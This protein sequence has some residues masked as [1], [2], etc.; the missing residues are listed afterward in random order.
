MLK[1]IFA[2]TENIEG[3]SGYVMDIIDQLLWWLLRKREDSDKVK[4]SSRFS[5]VSNLRLLI[6]KCNLRDFLGGPVAKTLHSQCR[7]PGFH[8]WTRS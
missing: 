4:K 5:H 3:V 2:P 6:T 1:K 8:P 7:L